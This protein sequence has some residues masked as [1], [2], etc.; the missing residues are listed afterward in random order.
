MRFDG[1]K[2]QFAI[3]KDVELSEKLDKLIMGI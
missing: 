3:L 2:K 1:D